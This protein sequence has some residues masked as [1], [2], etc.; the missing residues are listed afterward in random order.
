[1]VVPDYLWDQWL[2]R[3]DHNIQLQELLAVYLL[4]ESYPEEL[5]NCN[6][7]VFIDNA[8]VMHSVTRGRARAAEQNITIAHLWLRFAEFHV[9][10][11]C[12]QIESLAN[13]ADGPTR[14]FFDS[15]DILGAIET[16]A[17]LPGWLLD[18]WE[19]V[20]AENA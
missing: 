12:W 19:P 20:V 3:G 6:L 9:N 11:Q 2:D 10:L 5:F 4:I 8:S 15:L 1:M 7:T 17:I 18:L 14:H 16:Q 13:L